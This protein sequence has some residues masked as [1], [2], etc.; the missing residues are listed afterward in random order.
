MYG[1]T[2]P[3]ADIRSPDSS[4][5]IIQELGVDP[6]PTDE[7]VGL[8]EFV[9]VSPGVFTIMCVKGEMKGR[10]ISCAAPQKDDM[11]KADSG[12]ASYVVMSSDTSVT[13]HFQLEQV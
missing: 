5:A 2:D 9:V 6:W 1:G 8:W 12:E 11:R 7:A 13:G 4:Y 10:F 3:K